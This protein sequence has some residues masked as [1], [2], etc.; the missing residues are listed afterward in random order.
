MSNVLDMVIAGKSPQNSILQ[1]ICFDSLPLFLLLLLLLLL[2]L[3]LFL[4]LLLPLLSLLQLFLL[5][6]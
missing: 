6:S 5:C 3:F 2:L 4:L 1:S